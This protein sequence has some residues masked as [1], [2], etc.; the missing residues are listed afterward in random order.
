MR[1]IAVDMDFFTDEFFAQR[2]PSVWT[3]EYAAAFLGLSRIEPPDELLKQVSRSGGFEDN[4]IYAGVHTARALPG[5]ALFRGSENC[6]LRVKLA[7][8]MR[9]AFVPSTRFTIGC[10][11]S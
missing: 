2:G 1:W 8:R 4:F 6:T 3:R 9:C 11:H 7:D 5:D 10:S